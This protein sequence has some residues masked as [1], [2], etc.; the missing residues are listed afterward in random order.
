MWLYDG[1]WL[2]GSVWLYAC[3]QLYVAV[4]VPLCSCIC[5]CGVLRAGS[6][7]SGGRQQVQTDGNV[8]QTYNSLFVSGDGEMTLPSEIGILECN[9]NIQPTVVACKLESCLFPGIPNW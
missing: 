1:V 3:E 5:P 2:Y 8:W 7:L 6:E 4:C 9:V